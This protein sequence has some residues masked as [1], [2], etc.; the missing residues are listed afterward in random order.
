MDSIKVTVNGETHEVDRSDI[1]LPDNVD[2][3][4]PDNVPKGY[5]TQDAME[6]KIQDRVARAKRNA[7]SDLL[8]DKEFKQRVLS[9]Y[10]ISLDDS[11]NP[12][13]IKTQEDFEEWK[14]NQAQQ[15]TK[16][17][18][19]RIEELKQTASKLKSGSKKADILK[20]AN[21]L[22]QEQYTKSFMGDD[23]PFVVKQFGDKFD[24]DPETGQT[25][26]VDSEGGFAVDGD[27]SRI[28]PEK[29]FEQNK[30]KFNDLLQDKRQGSSKLQNGNGRKVGSYSDEEIANMSD[31][32][33]EQNRENILKSVSEN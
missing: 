13:G 28:T 4:S 24:V 8:D 21:G 27:G 10:G 20:A 19:E 18:K 3:I 22:F 25:A 2:F 23:D 7:E 12:K 16:P 6:Q 15:L 9:E 26:L 5:F 30:D 14:S 32:E 31:E 17:L 1:T 11:G 29:Y 33:Y